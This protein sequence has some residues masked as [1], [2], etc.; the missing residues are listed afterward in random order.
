MGPVNV[1]TRI[2][3]HDVIPIIALG[4]EQLQETGESRERVYNKR[5][6]LTLPAR[7]SFDIIARYKGL[8][9]GSSS[10]LPLKARVGRTCE[11]LAHH[12]MNKRNTVH[13]YT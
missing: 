13:V 10:V 5:M 9:S 3:G 4:M 2:L 6:V 1:I 11:A 7:G 8:V 12:L